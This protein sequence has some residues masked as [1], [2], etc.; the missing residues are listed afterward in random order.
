LVWL[1]ITTGK[2]RAETKESL[3]EQHAA[4]NAKL[5]TQDLGEYEVPEGLKTDDVQKAWELLEE[6]EKERDAKLAE[7]AA[8]AARKAAELAAEEA[9]KAAELAR[10]KWFKDNEEKIAILQANIRG[11]QARKAYQD[12]LNLFKQHEAFIEKV[13]IKPGNEFFFFSFSFF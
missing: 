4:I 8:E 3:K 11:A 10:A 2:N 5:A 6:K 12:R 1:L 7:A 13:R 9:K